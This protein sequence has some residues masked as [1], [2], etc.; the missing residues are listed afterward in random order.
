MSDPLMLVFPREEV[1]SQNLGPLLRR[2]GP[3]KLPR[4]RDLGR[5]MN[6][7]HFAVNGFD[8]DPHEVYAIESV[9][10]YYQ[11]LQ[12]DWPYAF[13]FCDLGG[14]SLMMLTMCC[15]G[16]LTGRKREGEALAS[17]EIDPMEL[18][19]FISGNWGP[20][21]SMCERAGMSERAIYERTGAIMRYYGLPFDVPG[22]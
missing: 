2:F 3:E 6:T 21:N 17:V 4:G 8:D 22:P 11:R 9:R 7:F 20:M 19:R 14:E 16:N 1:E 12:R 5:M 18:L 15:M 10:R 13:Y